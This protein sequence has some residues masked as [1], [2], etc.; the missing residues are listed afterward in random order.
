M[1]ELDTGRHRLHYEVIDLTA[2][3]IEAPETIVFH[4]GVGA[5]GRCWRGW[6]PALQDRYRLVTFDLPGHGQSPAVGAA[7][8]VPGLAADV[9]ALADGLDLARFHLVGESVGGTV[10]LQVAIA[11]PA[12]LSTLTVCNGAHLGSAV[13]HVDFWRAVIEGEGMAAWSARMMAARFHE[14]AL[15]AAAAAWFH[16]VQAGSDP[17]TVLAVL[18]ALVG[19]DLTPA[20][21]AIELPVLLLHPDASPFIPVP[22]MAELHR[23]LADA[24]LTVFPQS[25]HGLPFSHAA[26]CSR[27]LREFLDAVGES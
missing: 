23:R 18:D 20:L 10:A 12:R 21:A 14:D 16:A 24:R 8:T 2:P 26:A 19:T 27:A 15:P 9:L 1:A 17:E 6:A 22:V 5:N 4:H 3:W 7:I 11:A 25:R 13:E